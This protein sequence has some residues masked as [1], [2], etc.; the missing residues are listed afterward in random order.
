MRRLL[1]GDVGSG[2]TAVAV[3]ALLRAI[4]SGGQGAMMAPTETLARQHAATVRD[5]GRG[6]RDRGRPGS[7]T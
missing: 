6:A 7:N 5:A 3:H 2:K 1:I 4:E